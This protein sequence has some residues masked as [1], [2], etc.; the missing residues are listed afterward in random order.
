MRYRKSLKQLH[1]KMDKPM[2]IHAGN[3]NL[4]KA[5]ANQARGKVIL[6]AA[7]NIWSQFH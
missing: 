6:E 1:L 4:N 2:V 3:D 7:K 5:L